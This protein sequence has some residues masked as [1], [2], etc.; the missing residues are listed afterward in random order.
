MATTS[1][2]VTGPAP[3]LDRRELRSVRPPA[4]PLH[5][6]TGMAQR[7]QRPGLAR[8][9]APP[10]LPAQ[11]GV[12][13]ARPDLVGPRGQRRPRSTGPSCRRPSSPPTP[14]H[15][16]SGSVVHDAAEHLRPRRTGPTGPLV[17]LWTSFDPAT[18]GQAPVRGAQH[19]TTAAPGRRTPATRCSTS[20]PA[21]F[22]DPKVFR[23]RRRLGDGAGARRPA[24]RSSST[25]PPTCCTWTHHSSFG[26]E[27][28]VD[29]DWECPDLLRVPV[30][31]TSASGRRPARQR[32]R[33]R[34]RGRVGHA[35]LRRR[36]R[37]RRLPPRPSP[38]AGST[39][40]PTSTPR[41]PT[42][43]T[44]GPSRS[45]RRG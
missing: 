10:V 42:P 32:L 22:R 41:S 7:P 3:R 27:G 28:H 13:G 5:T 14:Q 26:P 35:V 24:A 36:A 11:P 1:V 23:A 43:A 20:A 8:R 33:R 45:C 31:G 39:T 19:R 38:R 21:S 17:A 37:R 16:W 12:A 2:P 34:T 30:E 4:R 18:G 44:P 15:A 40:A 9:R 6:A 29:A 25:A